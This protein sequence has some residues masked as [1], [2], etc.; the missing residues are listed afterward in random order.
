MVLWLSDVVLFLYTFVPSLTPNLVL[1]LTA[2]HSLM[3]RAKILVLL[4]F[5]VISS[6]GGDA[7]PFLGLVLMR[8]SIWFLVTSVASGIGSVV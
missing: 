3:Q 4:Q 2:W 8:L 7:I 5:L 6:R 1:E